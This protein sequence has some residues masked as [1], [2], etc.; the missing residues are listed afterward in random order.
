[1]DTK[2]IEEMKLVDYVFKKKRTF[3]QFNSFKLWLL[4]P[5]KC[6]RVDLTFDVF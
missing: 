2:T 1:M 4:K 6:W 3:T 5:N